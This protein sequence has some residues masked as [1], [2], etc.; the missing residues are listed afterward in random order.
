MLT[1]GAWCGCCGQVLYVGGPRE[2]GTYGCTGRVRGITASAE[3]KPA[4]SIGIAELDAQVSAW[5]TATYGA[6]EVMKKEWDPGTGHA[7][8]ISELTTART[9]LQSDRDAGLYDE[10]DQ[11]AWYQARHRS[12]TEE[13]KAL[14]AKKDRKPGMIEI[15]TGRTIGQEWEAA[16][17]ARR[18]EMLAEFSVRVVIHARKTP[19]AAARPAAGTKPQRVTITGTEAPT[20]RLLAEAA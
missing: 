12:L 11:A 1:G 3:C 18:R 19:A 6:G 20:A 7:A 8:Q 13:I 9:R 16:D 5:F 2:R 4:P 17:S 15:G 10:P 14:R